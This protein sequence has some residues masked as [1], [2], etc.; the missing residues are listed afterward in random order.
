MKRKRGN[1][2]INVLTKRGRWNGSTQIWRGGE[3][4]QDRIVLPTVDG[5]RRQV[6]YCRPIPVWAIQ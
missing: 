1:N 5:A 6:Q 4:G 3:C 2:S